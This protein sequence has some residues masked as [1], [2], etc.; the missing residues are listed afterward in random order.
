MKSLEEELSEVQE[1]KRQNRALQV[2]YPKYKY[3]LELSLR[4]L[5]EIENEIIAAI[6]RRDVK[7][8]FDD[9]MRWYE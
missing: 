6:A 3:G 7:H 2:K 1:L 9:M 5:E 8:A 4:S